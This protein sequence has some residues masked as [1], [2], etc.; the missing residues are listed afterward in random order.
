MSIQTVGWALEQ[1]DIP[2]RPKLV[3]VAIANHAN[4]ED[5]YCWLKAETIAREAACTPRSVFNFV[6]ALIRNGF[7]RKALRKS[8]DGKQRASDYWILF[9]REE[10]P[11]E[12]V[13]H[14]DE[15]G[16]EGEPSE[17]TSSADEAQDVV[18]PDEPGACGET[19]E[20]HERHDTRQPVEMSPRACGPHASTFHRKRIAEPSESKS[21]ASSAGARVLKSTLRNYRPP[22][23]QPL[24]ADT[25]AK[26]KPVFAYEGSRAYEAW[27]KVEAKKAGLRTWNL[28]TKANINGHWCSGWWFP[29]LFP[30]PEKSASTADPPNNLSESD[31]Q[32]LKEHNL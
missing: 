5:G 10:K 19:A 1:Q 24:G 22:P 6:G 21:K 11:W 9:D 18:L 31:V 3:L 28:T 29:T 26:T 23:P 27:A 17:N 16:A 2:A 20:P 14:V 12:T 32:F 7:I 13:A 30:P 4:H 25:E 15:D 8:D